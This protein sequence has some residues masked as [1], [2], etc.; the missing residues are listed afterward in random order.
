MAVSYVR[1]AL[2]FYITSPML[3]NISCDLPCGKT[4]RCNEIQWDKSP[5]VHRIPVL[6]YILLSKIALLHIKIFCKTNKSGR[7]RT[8]IISQIY[9]RVKLKGQWLKLESQIL[10]LQ[11]IN[12]YKLRIQSENHN[13]N[14][15][16]FQS[17]T[18]KRWLK[19]LRLMS[20]SQ[21]ANAFDQVV[22]L[23]QVLSQ[24]LKNLST[25]AVVLIL[26]NKRKTVISHAPFISC[27]SSKQT[28]LNFWVNVNL[29]IRVIQKNKSFIFHQANLSFYS[30]M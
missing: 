14:K 15:E 28:K 10:L 30:L 6:Y 27:K 21:I 8:T 18:I 24:E 1:F 9:F 12:F 7:M 16:L 19:S 23:L 29:D 13:E 4:K 2:L 26:K 11:F 17:Q 25:T 5:I 22:S 3:Q 20:Q